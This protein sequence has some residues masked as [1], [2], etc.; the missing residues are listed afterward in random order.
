MKH[1]V[2]FDF[3]VADYEVSDGKWH[4]DFLDNNGA[5]FTFSDAERVAGE[6]RSNTFAYCRNIEIVKIGE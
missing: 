5:G 3:K 1:K 2:V 4:R 6:L